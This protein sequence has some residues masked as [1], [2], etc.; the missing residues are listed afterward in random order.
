MRA[1]NQIKFNYLYHEFSFSERTR[2]KNFLVNMFKKEGFKIDSINYIFCSDEYLLELNKVNLNHNTYTDIITFPYSKNNEPIVA[3]I[4]IS[5]ERVKENSKIFSTNFK[6]E[7]HRVIF[8]GA[9]HLCGYKDKSHAE[10]QQMRK[11]ESL[12]LKK[13]FVPRET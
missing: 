7:L 8:H 1:L 11:M 4:F 10:I 3:D 13:Y 6:E 2:L 5:V 12:Y 9:L